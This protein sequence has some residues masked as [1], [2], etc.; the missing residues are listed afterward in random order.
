MEL[1][2]CD[3]EASFVPRTGNQMG[4]AD[5]EWQ[6]LPAKERLRHALQIIGSSP[7]D[8]VE[9]GAA[10]VNDGPMSLSVEN[11]QALL[12]DTE[13]V[14]GA[15]NSFIP[16]DMAVV[17]PAV[18]WEQVHQYLSHTL[19]NCNRLGGSVVVFGS[20]DSRQIP[21][22]YEK[23]RAVA[24]V[25]RFLKMN[26]DI[27]ETQGLDLRIAVEALNVDECNFLNTLGE[28]DQVVRQTGSNRVGLLV[29][30]YHMCLQE[31]DY[32]AELEQVL[33]RVNHIQIVE[34][35]TRRR[36]GY[37]GESAF[38]YGKFFALLNER[39]YEGKL[40]VEAIFKRLGDEISPCH[41]FLKAYLL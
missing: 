16:P 5:E 37:G 18:N 13:V 31:N 9:M 4:V 28:V 15:Y 30:C 7:F 35:G 22:D 36:P 41:K 33:D 21:D 12:D 20:G 40:S 14:I 19:A 38:E 32:W 39:Q 8:F 6:V 17:G 10:W 29:D 3:M 23:K 25:V 26:A 11:I 34:P 27:I 24:D 2:I 1:G